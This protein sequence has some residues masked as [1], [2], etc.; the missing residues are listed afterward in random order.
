MQ[1]HLYRT[2]ERNLFQTSP[3]CVT[4]EPDLLYVPVHG[5][6]HF[7]NPEFSTV[8]HFSQYGRHTGK[9]P[10]GLGIAVLGDSFAMGWGVSDKDTFAAELQRLSARP[11]YN[12]GVSSYGTKRE[13]LYLM[14][15]GL[16]S[17][18]D[19]IIIQ[20]CDN[21][22]P[23]NIQFDDL[24]QEGTRRRFETL[25]SD[26]HRSLKQRL[27]RVLR[28]YWSTLK[29]PFSH[30]ERQFHEETAKSFAPHYQPLINTLS[31]SD[32]VGEKRIVIFYLRMFGKR[33]NSFPV[34]KDSI[35][36][37]L[38]FIDIDLARGDFLGL[39][40]HLNAAGHR[41]VGQALFSLLQQ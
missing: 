31:Q 17:D 21:D 37:N 27:K 19:T 1:G 28:A 10:D 13:L 22:R 23:E 35:I 11:V 36:P 32:I 12:L 4:F 15:S 9:K 20:Y 33:F 2:G 5:E 16:A 8:M 14:K 26:D 7:E 6:C 41:K 30:D 24:T 39:D 25:R 18:V 34:G 40:G 3:G 29:A 38:E